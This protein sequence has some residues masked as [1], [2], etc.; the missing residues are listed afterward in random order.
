MSRTVPLPAS[1]RPAQDAA[2]AVVS[3]RNLSVGFAPH[4]A[5]VDAVSFSIARGECLAIVGESGSGKSVTARSLLGL[6]GAGAWVRAD[7]LQ[8][9]GSPHPGLAERMPAGEQ[10]GSCVSH[11]FLNGAA[12]HRGGHGREHDEQAGEEAHPPARGD[13]GAP[14]REHRAPLCSWRLGAEAQERQG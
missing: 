14:G 13:V 3:V 4:T 5:V 2:S 1:A 10:Y 9:K 6:A 7:D 8:I 11:P 12:E